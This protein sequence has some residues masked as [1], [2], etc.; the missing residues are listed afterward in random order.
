MKQ[1]GPSSL[2]LNDVQ[3]V[4]AETIFKAPGAI[5]YSRIQLVSNWVN[6]I[7]KI[8]HS[9]PLVD[10][11]EL[12]ERWNTLRDLCQ[13]FST[14]LNLLQIKTMNFSQ[15]YTSV[16]DHKFFNI[17]SSVCLINI[18]VILNNIERIFSPLLSECSCLVV[19]TGSMKIHQRDIILQV[20]CIQSREMEL[21]SSL[22]MSRIL[23]LKYPKILDWN[24]LGQSL[25]LLWFL[26][27]AY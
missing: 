23:I 27:C 14:K 1:H 15:K 4:T 12:I 16:F 5:D 25:P 22:K 3:W 6:V 21:A 20:W 13:I 19:T 26:G 7:T 9:N 17:L 2:Y 18:D 8:E 24:L 11:W 10:N